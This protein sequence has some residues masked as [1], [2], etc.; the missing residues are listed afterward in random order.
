M[1]CPYFN[2]RGLRRPRRS[3]SGSS[4]HMFIFQSTRP[5]QTSTTKLKSVFTGETISIHEAFAD[6]DASI[7]GIGES[8]KDFNPRGLRRPRRC[9]LRISWMGIPISIHE[10]FADLDPDRAKRMWIDVISIHEAFADL[11]EPQSVRWIPVEFQSTRPS[12]TSTQGISTCP[13]A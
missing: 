6:L 11:D 9:P 2:P 5:S 4:F 13:Q 12:Q 8:L 1:P 3:G 7:K 10:A